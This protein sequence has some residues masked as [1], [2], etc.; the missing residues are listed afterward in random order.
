MIPRT[1]NALLYHAAI[2]CALLA[3]VP[4][5]QAQAPAHSVA[6]KACPK[7]R[8]NETRKVGDYLIRQVDAAI[9]NDPNDAEDVEY[10]PCLEVRKAGRILFSE[11]DEQRDYV[12]GNG[13]YPESS[14]PKPGEP[15]MKPG[16]DLTGLGVPNVLISTF[17]GGAHCC[18][19]FYLFE[20][21]E[22]F[23][24]LKVDAGDGD[25]SHAEYDAA[26][27][28]W[29]FRLAD[30]NF[31]Y[32]KTSFVD[33]PAPSIVLSVRRDADGKDAFHLDWD[34]MRQPAPTQAEFN[35]MVKETREDERWKNS[36]NDQKEH[37]PPALWANMLDLIYSGNTASAFQ[38]LDATWP[39]ARKGKSTFTSEFCEQIAHSHYIEDLRPVLKPLPTG[40]VVQVSK[41]NNSQ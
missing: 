27:H 25:G 17:S 39:K 20:L 19:G 15:V 4:A 10:H 5:L 22:K 28:S 33:S 30:W 3:T 1:L 26:R 23:N 31:N 24:L 34:K 18:S 40:C 13:I 35:K 32:W 2:S 38:L 9:H 21:G 37:I 12:F 8:V 14:K 6:P 36:D 16:D 11:I 41:K 7:G 29:Y